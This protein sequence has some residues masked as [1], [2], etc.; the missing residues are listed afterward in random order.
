MHASIS[1]QQNVILR[2]FAICLLISS[3][4]F[5]LRHISPWRPSG[6][7]VWC[8]SGSLHDGYVGLC[9]GL[10]QI[11]QNRDNLVTQ[12]QENPQKTKT[13]KQQ[14]Q[15]QKIGTVAGYARSALDI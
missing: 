14:K 12:N 3:S 8:P 5:F 9:L 15:K 7:V 4:S 13:K 11:T 6:S 1:D 2:R 10:H